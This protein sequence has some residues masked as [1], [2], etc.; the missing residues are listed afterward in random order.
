MT[1]ELN[2]SSAEDED[3]TADVSSAELED[4]TDGEE[5]W[6]AQAGS[7]LQESIYVV[8]EPVVSF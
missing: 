8:T 7:A 6:D 2:D 4:A 3:T 5:T 1:A